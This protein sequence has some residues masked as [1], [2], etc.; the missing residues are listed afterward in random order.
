MICFTVNQSKFL[1]KQVYRLNECDTLRS[2]CEAQLSDCD[3]ISKSFSNVKKDFSMFVENSKSEN[4]IYE[5]EITGLKAELKD[6]KRKTRIQ[7][8]YKV[9]AIGVG[10]AATG[11]MTYLWIKK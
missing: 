11:F 4:K 7:K 2:I 8:V 6:E 3:S 1:L 10:S 9:I 5:Y